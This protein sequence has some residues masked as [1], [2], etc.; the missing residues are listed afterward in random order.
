MEL[1]KVYSRYFPFSG[2]LALTIC[3]FVFIRKK[4]K[5]RYT[6]KVNRHETTHA[7]QQVETMW[8][9]FFVLYGLEWLI[10]WFC[11]KFDSHRAYRSISFE[12][13]AYM[14]ENELYYNDLRK[15]YA[16]TKYIFRLLNDKK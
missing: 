11:C 7:L 12:Q 16:W 2:F 14:H 5:E 9:L 10:K 6:A 3:P 1:I 8:I 4:A 13:E 15:F